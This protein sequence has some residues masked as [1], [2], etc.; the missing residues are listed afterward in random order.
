MKW[1]IHL[2]SKWIKSPPCRATSSVNCRISDF[3]TDTKAYFLLIL[4]FTIFFFMSFTKSFSFLLSYVDI[5]D[6]LLA[7]V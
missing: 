5:C 1:S 3:V 2:L 7:V 6:P 4:Q